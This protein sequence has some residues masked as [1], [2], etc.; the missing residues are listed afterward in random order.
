MTN[1]KNNNKAKNKPKAKP[2]RQAPRRPNGNASVS[3]SR[4]AG[5]SGYSII[6]S[7]NTGITVRGKEILGSVTAIASAVGNTG[8]L[9]D[10]N[11]ACWSNSRLALL[12]RTY[13]KYRFT[14]AKIRY[15]PSVA[16]SET[17][18]IAMYVETDPAER[19]VT[20][21]AAMQIIANMQ[22]S[23][24]GPVWSSVE[25]DFRVDRNDQD[26]Y[27]CSVA[28]ITERRECTQFMIAA[29]C[30]GTSFPA[31]V[32]AKDIGW[33]EIEYE[34]QFA[35]QEL[36]IGTAGTQYVLDTLTIPATGAGAVTSIT[37]SNAG[38][39]PGGSKLAEIRFAETISNV[40][41]ERL[42]QF[43]NAG[44]NIEIVPGMP[45]YLGWAGDA[46]RVYASLA[47]ARVL[48]PALG[49]VAAKAQTQLRAFVRPLADKAE[50]F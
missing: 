10:S 48:G 25:F 21:S 47:A 45:L 32:A 17:G 49:W 7:T 18:A 24:M 9:F 11:P 22:F 30:F 19:L 12:A 50:S 33:V 35:Y 1:N 13:E 3:Y 41:N 4:L 43:G 8:A 29:N 23:R 2:N 39:L 37:G 34:L 6:G 38:S 46:W 28:G 14:R 27:F 40:L 5:A 15:V 44:N 36:E 26:M 20:G 16:T 42:A 31:G